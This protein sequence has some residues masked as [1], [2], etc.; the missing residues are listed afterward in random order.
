[1]AWSS[2]RSVV[3]IAVAV[4]AGTLAGLPL[5]QAATAPSGWTV[6]PPAHKPGGF[7]DVAAVSATE[8]WAV[9]VT[10]PVVNADPPKIQ[11]L[12]EHNTGTGWTVVAAPHVASGARLTA[13]SARAAR[14]VWAVG[15]VYGTKFSP[16]ALHYEGGA[17]RRV[18]NPA[19]ATTAQFNGVFAR[20]ATDVW[21]VGSR[22]G[23]PL[24]ERWTGKAW[25]LVPV[26]APANASS[27]LNDVVAL[28]ASNAWAVGWSVP[29]GTDEDIPVPLV[30]HWNGHT[31]RIVPVPHGPLTHNG[32][33]LRAVTAV[34]AN[35]IWA[36]G[37]STIVLHYNGQGWKLVPAPKA[38][39]DPEVET[40]LNA[41]SA[42][43]ARD[44]W[45]VGTVGTPSGPHTV[46]EHW[47]GTAWSL[48]PSP[49]PAPIN[50]LN[51]VAAPRGG[52]TIAVGSVQ[53]GLVSNPLVLRNNS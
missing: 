30:E 35:D 52:P 46:T 39:R 31:W 20:S 43:S 10:L 16:L 17:W 36:V 29:K 22:G 27:S 5:A 24:I 44:I 48:V 51:G 21:A 2:S 49:S 28:S 38:S 41:V 15:M 45:M 7:A 19:I 4:A 25:Q 23:D 1:M 3:V 34:S 8:L 14:D 12:I 42:R 50:Y 33:D 47:N 9:G 6:V 13:V 32:S 26:P 11:P 40:A 18:P 53:R 37:G